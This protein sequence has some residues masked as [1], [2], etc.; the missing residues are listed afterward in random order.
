MK[1]PF[2]PVVK[3]AMWHPYDSLKKAWRMFPR[4]RTLQSFM[5]TIGELE[6]ME[7]N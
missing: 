4:A 5:G 2:L 7:Q 6:K 3:N 1:V